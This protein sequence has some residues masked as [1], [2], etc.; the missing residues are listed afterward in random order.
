MPLASIKRFSMA[1][2]VAGVALVLLHNPG[3]LAQTNLQAPATLSPTCVITYAGTFGSTLIDAKLGRT[4]K[5]APEQMLDQNLYLGQAG[6]QILMEIGSSFGVLR[7]ISNILDTQNINL[8]ITH[9]EMIN[10]TGQASTR[11]IWSSKIDGIGD[12]YRFDFRYA[13]VP[14]KWTFDYQYR[15]KSL[16]QQ[17]FELR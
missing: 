2:A 13:M 3:A 6:T 17:S 5:V 7:K 11:T 12:L 10:P 16:C 4:P 1:L 15:G 14:G 9:P 8:V